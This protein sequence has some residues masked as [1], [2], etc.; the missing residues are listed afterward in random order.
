MATP[1]KE[2][3]PIVVHVDDP[4]NYQPLHDWLYSDAAGGDESQNL[5]LQ[6]RANNLNVPVEVVTVIS[7]KVNNLRLLTAQVGESGVELGDL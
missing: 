5:S 6:E 3:A 4:E 2:R 1:I 7:E